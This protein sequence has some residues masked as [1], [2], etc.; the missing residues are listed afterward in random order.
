MA[1][2]LKVIVDVDAVVE[3]WV[4][5][6]ESD[7][8]RRDEGAAFVQLHVLLVLGRG[9]LVGHGAA[10]ARNPITKAGDTI[11]AFSVHV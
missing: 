7:V 8:A 1:C 3:T 4:R 10:A 11:T 6:T 2:S 5:G 9:L